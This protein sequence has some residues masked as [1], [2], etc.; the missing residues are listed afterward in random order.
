MPERLKYVGTSIVLQ[1]VPDEITLAISVSNCKHRCP[2]C[3]S[4]Y[5]WEDVGRYLTDDIADIV[6]QNLG[7]VSC[8]CIM[9]GDWNVRELNECIDVIHN[10]GLRCCL[11]LGCDH[12]P[13]QLRMVDYLKI[14]HYDRDKGGLDVIGTNQQM[15]KNVN[16][17]YV[18]ITS[19]F[20]KAVEI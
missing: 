18:D 5:L 11:Y 2:G 9:G 20:Q 1:E 12:V 17:A 10:R 4:P 8:V 7:L 13:E 14:G 6:L 19:R 16:G 3:H 15:L